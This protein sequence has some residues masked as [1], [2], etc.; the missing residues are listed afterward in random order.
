MLKFKKNAKI[1]QKSKKEAE[2]FISDISDD[3]ELDKNIE[4]DIFNKNFNENILNYLEQCL[5]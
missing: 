2:D 4:K 1:L 3:D 5:F